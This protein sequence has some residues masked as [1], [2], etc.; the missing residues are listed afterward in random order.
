MTLLNIPKYLRCRLVIPKAHVC[1]LLS[2]FLFISP[3]VGNVP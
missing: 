2:V 1:Y 3:N